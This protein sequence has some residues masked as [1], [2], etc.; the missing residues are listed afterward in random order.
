VP[1]VEVDKL[2]HVSIKKAE[3]SEVVRR[4]VQKARNIQISRFAKLPF[5]ANGDMSTKAVKE[6]CTL[7]SEV[8]AFLRQAVVQMHLSARSYYRVI[9]LGRTIAD[10]SEQ[11]QMSIQHV[12]EALQYRPKDVI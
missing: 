9:K 5:Q 11:E 3:T 6:L 10:L 8:L 7:S 12:A 2:V 1:E 4:R